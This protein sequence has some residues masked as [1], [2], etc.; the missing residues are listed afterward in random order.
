MESQNEVIITEE[1][2]LGLIDSFTKV[3]SIILKRMVSANLNVVKSFESQIQSYKSQLSPD[4]LL[5]I[6]K[7][8]NMSVSELQEILYSAY[9]STNKKQ[10][11]IL[12][13]SNA[14]PFIEKN[15]SQL[16]KVLYNS[17]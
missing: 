11:K 7:V 5:K 4:D 8:L 9:E 12:A 16:E 3:P 13:D 14:G 6:E 17:N 15:L 1:D 2:V 10:L